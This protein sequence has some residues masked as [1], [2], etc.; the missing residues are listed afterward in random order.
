M[1]IKIWKILGRGVL[2][3]GQKHQAY[4]YIIVDDNF[5][6]RKTNEY[7]ALASEPLDRGDIIRLINKEI[8]LDDFELNG[9]NPEKYPDEDWE[10]AEQLEEDEWDLIL[11]E[12]S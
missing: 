11:K 10:L 7:V 9:E 8:D 3:D 2:P 1:T 4:E 6:I 12:L 5:H